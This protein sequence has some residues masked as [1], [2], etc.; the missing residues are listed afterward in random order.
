MNKLLT[1]LAFPKPLRRA[2][3]GTLA[4]GLALAQLAQASWV[5]ADAP[6]SVRPGSAVSE[7][8]QVAATDWPQL[9]QNAQRTNATS[10]QVNGPYCYAWKWTGVPFPARAQPVVAS[11]RLFFGGMDGVL[12]ARNA[13]TGQALWQFR[14]GGPIRHSAGVWNNVV[15]VSSHDGFTYGLNVTNGSQIWKTATGPSATAPLI[16]NGRGSAIVGSTN[17]TLTSL[18]ADSGTARWSFASGAAILTSAALSA[19]GSLVFF[20]SEAIQAIALNAQTGALVWRKTI[21]GQTLT[22]RYPVVIGS[23]V[24]YRSMPIYHFHQLLNEGDAVLDSAGG[25][26]SN[27]ASDWA[28]IRS[29]IISYLT[30]QPSKQ[31]MFVLD[32]ATGN[33]RGVPP[34][35]YTYGNS[36]VPAAPVA[37]G[38]NVYVAYRPRHGIQTD[39][40]SNHVTTEY[41]AELGRMDLG[42]LDITGLTQSNGVSYQTQF[43]LTS[44]EPATLT[45]GGNILW[46]DNWER[47]GGFDTGNGQILY[48]G[49]VSNVWPECY[50]GNS[51]G[52]AGTNPVFPLTG[53][54]QAYPFQS[55]RVTDGGTQPGVVIANSM[56]YWR[57][58]ESGL[59]ALKTGPCGSPQVWTTTESASMAQDQASV[60]TPAALTPR[61]YLPTIT[62]SDA[63]KGAPNPGGP[64]ERYIQTDLTRPNTNPPGDLVDR[65][66]NEVR[67]MLDLANG[68]HLMPYYLDRGFSNSWVWP[69]NAQNCQP[70]TSGCLAQISYSADGV[71]SNVFWFD[72]G[73][74]L[75]TMAMAYPYLD[76]DLRSRLTV[77]MS[78]EMNRYPPLNDLPYNDTNRD[79]LRSGVAREPYA[80]PQRGSLNSWPT[81]A[82]NI[83]AI[84]GLWLWSK[85]TNDYTYACSHWANARVLY[86]SRKSN[87]RYYSDIGGVIGYVR[88]GQD[89]RAKGCAAVTAADVSGAITV[90]MNALQTGVGN[91]AFNAHRDAAEND[92]I[93]P[94]GIVT[95]WSVPVFFGLTPEIGLYL[96]DQS[97]NSAQSYLQARETGDGVRWWYLTRVGTHAEEGETSYLLPITGWSHFMAQAYVLGT[98]QAVLRTYLDR[99]WTVGDL[100]SI[101]R[102]VATIQA[103]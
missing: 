45:M 82:A 35:L 89:L 23:T 29:K 51:C 47:L 52:P 69:Y 85:N 79:W 64:L 14:T 57:V 103:P 67:A 37:Q 34:V 59:V 70:G 22:D 20:G 4:V 102:L 77:Y 74:L 72:P 56:V 32:S 41:D 48:A 26:Q 11:G 13:T 87:L 5:R 19:D 30:D 2:L 73:E 91:A 10:L 60:D 8:D 99:P 88:L 1:L 49:N 97:S 31:S 42:S 66:R 24:I 38:S 98:G 76:A 84:Y 54:G 40:G 65:V 46:V 50:A 21:Q 12:Y 53:S 93:D 55:P 39:G 3:H 62:Q 63:P 81:P 92:Y 58:I 86:D 18:A 78:A 27:W 7:T 90:A 44:D 9:G 33:S 80:V 15:I 25:L 75:Y 83:S 28:T 61:L 95:G 101:Q 6:A 36:D 16:D 100:Y 43:R 96:R 17:G 71:Y 94:R 68:Q